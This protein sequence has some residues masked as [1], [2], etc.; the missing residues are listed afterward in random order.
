M[1]FNSLYFLVMIP[2]WMRTLGYKF[3]QDGGSGIIKVPYRNIMTSLT[4]LIV[5]LILG[6]LIARYLPNVAAKA[7]KTLRPFVIF[8]LVFVITF[9]TISHWYMLKHISWPAVL[10]G[11]LLPFGGF[12]FGCLTSILLKQKPKDVAAI[13]IETGVQNTGIAIMILKVN[14]LVTLK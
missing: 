11:F 4:V 13:A 10:S 9:G 5:P 1:T 14:I 7:R 2:F 12:A 8:V 6:I 3:L